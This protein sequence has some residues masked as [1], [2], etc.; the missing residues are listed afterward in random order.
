MRSAKRV[1]IVLVLLI[2]RLT[3]LLSEQRAIVIEARLR[4]RMRARASSTR[5]KNSI[6]FS[7]AAN[8]GFT[9]G[10]D[11]AWKLSML[12]E[13]IKTEMRH[14]AIIRGRLSKRI[15]RINEPTVKV[16]CPCAQ[17][18]FLR[19]ISFPSSARAIFSLILKRIAAE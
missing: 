6:N 1:I 18:A 12:I 5:R 10:F 16:S 9:I 17:T 2:M 11:S 13:I 8:Q 14:Q 7:H 15:N 4:S 19:T 3:Q